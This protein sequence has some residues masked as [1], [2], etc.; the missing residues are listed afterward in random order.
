M[1]RTNL[2]TVCIIAAFACLASIPMLRGLKNQR[3]PLVMD[4]TCIESGVVEDF[5]WKLNQI[6]VDRADITDGVTIHI[7]HT[8]PNFAA[9][10]IKTGQ[11]NDWVKLAGDTCS[12]SPQEVRAGFSIKAKNLFGEET[13]AAY[14]AVEIKNSTVSV[15]PSVISR[16]LRDIPFR[17][18]QYTAP[19]MLFM[20]EQTLPVAMAQ[21]G[22]WQKF[23]ALRS[24]VKAT[25]PFG[26]PR[27]DSNWNAAAIL[28]AAQSNP[29]A[30]FL[31]DEYAAVFVTSCISVGLNARMIH[32]RSEEGDG[33]YA[34]EVWSEEQQK[35]VYM[36]PLYDFSYCEEGSCFSALDLHNLYL[37][38]G[39]DRY[40]RLP[41]S[42]PQKNYLNLFHEFQ[43]IMA[44]DFLSH[45]YNGVWDLVRGRI[46]SLRWTDAATPPLDKWHAAAALLL[47]YYA[48]RI[49]IPLVM[50]IGL[51]AAIGVVVFSLKQKQAKA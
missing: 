18:E 45:P 29:R 20:R 33:H 15:T 46:P 1:N 42:F 26:N 38:I 25:I 7:S 43:I 6:F 21:H 14:Y 35:W 23:L 49:G 28:R 5:Y 19:G 32:L 11:G 51:F 47:Y 39:N 50:V 30:A 44:N 9:Y 22:E 34:A 24:W 40:R 12:F 27:K 10:Y 48:P 41:P 13:A 4:I 16:T 36:D 3:H 17:F 31:C 8:V 2:R 37:K